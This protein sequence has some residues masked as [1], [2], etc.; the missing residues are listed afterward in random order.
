MRE[1]NGNG[2]GNETGNETGEDPGNE[3]GEDGNQ[4][5][6]E[7]IINLTEEN[8]SSES[9]TAILVEENEQTTINISTVGFTE[10]VSQPV[11]IH[12]GDC[13]NVSTIAYPLTNILNGESITVINV[14]LSQLESELPLAINVHKSINESSVYVACGNLT[15]S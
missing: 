11:H 2:D 9:G 7:L 12:L 15:F 6:V 4:T 10:N 14:T 3:T 1:D 5:T 13:L 8:N